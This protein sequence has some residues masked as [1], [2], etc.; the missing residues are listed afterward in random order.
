M[1]RVTLDLDDPHPVEVQRAWYRLRDA[2]VERVQGRVS[3]SG[4]GVH[5]RAFGYDGGREACDRLRRDAG[6]H[7]VRVEYDNVYGRKPRQILFDSKGDNDAGPWV[8]TLPSI[9]DAYLQ[10]TRWRWC[11]THRSMRVTA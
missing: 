2:G 6:D 1:T 7:G 3:S 5:L 10:A 9:I 11:A 4:D 8:D